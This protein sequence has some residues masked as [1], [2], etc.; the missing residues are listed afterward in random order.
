MLPTYISFGLYL[1]MM[2]FIGM[3]FYDRKS[4]VDNYILGGRGLGSWVTAMSAQ[5]S[6]MSGWLLMGLPGSIYLAGSGDTWC[7]IGLAIGTLF[8]WLLV[9]PRIRVYSEITDSLTVCSFMGDRFKDPTGIIRVA[10][11]LV[12]FGFFAIYAGSGLVAAGKL[13][14]NMFHINYNLAVAIGA[15]V[16]LVYTLCGGFLAVCYTDLIQGIL[17]FIAVVVIPILAVRTLQCGDIVNTMQERGITMSLVPAQ[18][19]QMIDNTDS[20]TAYEGFKFITDKAFFGLLAIISPLVWGLGYFGQPHIVVRFMGIKSHKALSK[21]TLIAMIWVVVSLTAAVL[22]G[23]IGIGMYKDPTAIDSEKVFIHMI[24]DVCNPWIGGI[25]LAAIMAAIMSTI[26]SQLL[27]ASSALAQDFYKV[28]F[29]KQASEKEMLHVN[30]FFVFLI[31]TFAT[32]VALTDLKTIFAIVKFAWGGFG[33]AFGPVILMALYARRTTWQ[34]ALLGMLTGTAVMLTW[35]FTGINAYMYEILPAFVANLL[36]IWIINC[37]FPQDDPAVLA[38]FDK[39]RG[40][41]KA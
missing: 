30:R 39:M 33:A 35:Y 14:E 4:S 19:L 27:A 29:R 11:A 5:A 26:D 17:M 21:A 3:A 22:I 7:A 15:V 40:I 9:A 1:I 6:D 37:I 12:T 36:V 32:C 28:I 16:V 13:F 34:S 25:F 2:I 18:W 10:A 38:E 20:M 31:M 41:I 24:H 8:N 23:T